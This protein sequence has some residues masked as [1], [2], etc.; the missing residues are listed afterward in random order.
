MTHVVSTQPNAPFKRYVRA[1]RRNIEL[2]TDVREA[3]RFYQRE[4]VKVV[5]KIYSD[6]PGCYLQ[7]EKL[8]CVSHFF[9]VEYLNQDNIRRM[10]T[11]NVD[12]G[13]YESFCTYF[14]AVRVGFD[15]LACDEADLRPL[16]ESVFIDELPCSDTLILGE[17]EQK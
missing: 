15:Q 17:A 16:G 2:V 3:T 5:P 7:Y 10:T 11:E 12:A 1:N 8:V 9:Y 4:L 13:E 14:I 6:L